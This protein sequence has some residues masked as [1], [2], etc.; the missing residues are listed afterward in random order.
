M[1]HL[2][3]AYLKENE[4]KQIQTRV[5]QK[6]Y[7]QVKYD[8]TNWQYLNP[9]NITF[10]PEDGLKTNWIIIHYIEELKYGLSN[11]CK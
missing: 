10:T 9:T 6:G 2:S 3:S 7:H 5:W 11:Q 8:G 1:T 4:W